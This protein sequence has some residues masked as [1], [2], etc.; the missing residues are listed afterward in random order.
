MTTYTASG[1]FDRGLWQLRRDADGAIASWRT[2][3]GDLLP[4]TWDTPEEAQRF[5]TLIGTPD[6][7]AATFPLVWM[8]PITYQEVAA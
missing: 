1:D 6:F 5:G 3:L 4:R 7:P 2:T 8:N